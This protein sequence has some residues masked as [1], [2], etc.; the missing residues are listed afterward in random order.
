MKKRIQSIQH[1]LRGLLA[2]LLLTG[3]T[4][5][6]AAQGEDQTR[7]GPDELP[8]IV[9]PNGDGVNDVFVLRNDKGAHM[10]LSLFTRD[11]SLVYTGEGSHIVFDGRN[12]RGD[13]LT[14][15]TY[16]YTLEDPSNTYGKKNG[17]LH[18]SRGKVRGADQ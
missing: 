10:V 11:G 7:V 9:T 6:A 12:A 8:N 14:T 2:L 4:A 5:R 1:A 15:G 13:E 16:F 18:I 17:V 3:L